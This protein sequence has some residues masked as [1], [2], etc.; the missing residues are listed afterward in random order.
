MKAL[1]VNCVDYS[2]LR[3]RTDK[4]YSNYIDLPRTK[5]DVDTIESSLK[6][7]TNVEIIK[8]PNPSWREMQ[9]ALNDIE[10][11]ADEAS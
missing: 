8:L 5:I 7:F 2:K 10:D 1:L 6:H 11:E 3:G 4:D 9:D